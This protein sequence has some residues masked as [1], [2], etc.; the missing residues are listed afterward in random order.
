MGSEL[1]T[2]LLNILRGLRGTSKLPLSLS[3]Y[4]FPRGGSDS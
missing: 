2:V 1:L 4:S 3:T